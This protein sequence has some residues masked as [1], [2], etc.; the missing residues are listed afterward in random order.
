MLSE[1]KSG[2]FVFEAAAKVDEKSSNDFLLKAP[3]YPLNGIFL[4]DSINYS[5]INGRAG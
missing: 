1:N 4:Y 5:K 3:P 2:T